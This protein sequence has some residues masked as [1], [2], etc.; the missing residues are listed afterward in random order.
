MIRKFQKIQVL[1]VSGFLLLTG[2]MV[3][4]ASFILIVEIVGLEYTLFI[5]NYPIQYQA[6]L[7]GVISAL[8][9]ICCGGSGKEKTD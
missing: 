2:N 1:N 9:S 7:I 8:L 5:M 6:M 3:G 4:L